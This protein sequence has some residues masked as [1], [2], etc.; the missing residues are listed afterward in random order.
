MTAI[1][2]PIGAGLTIGLA[3][4]AALIS[5][6]PLQAQPQY[7]EKPLTLVVPYAAG[8]PMDKLARELAEP[9]RQQL[10]QPVIVQNTAGAGGNIGAMQVKNALPDGYTLLLNHIGM[11][12]APALYRSLQYRPETD[13]AP[14]GIVAE[15][16]LVLVSRSGVPSASVKELER[17][18]DSR[19]QTTM[20][21]AGV[22]SA[23]HLC[24]L[25]LQS[26]LK[27][28]LITVP[29]RG[30]GPAIV[31]LLG[32]QVDLLCDLT[33]NA[34]GHVAAGKL[35]PI[36]VTSARPL[37]GTALGAV[38]TMRE[39]GL[40]DVEL[41]VWYGL[42]AP[43]G[44]PA[45]VQKTLNEALQAAARTAPFQQAQGAA[46]IQTVTDQR[47]TPAGHREYLQR[48]LGR[49]SAVI[50]AAGIYAD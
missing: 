5:A 1:K 30:T 18:M 14:L 29:Y 37:T 13:F 15:S 41:S 24:G 28:S 2:A 36:A 4:L 43:R 44:T 26:S 6:G 20:A 49:W 32:G 38:P 31:D 40:P 10:R 47:A 11:A 46:G 42:Y 50:K 22:G 7:P 12:T 8:G 27:K 3:A 23:S 16:P 34:L 9:M 21:N 39:I 17:W 33:A 19:A 35:R 25:L 45:P 48:E